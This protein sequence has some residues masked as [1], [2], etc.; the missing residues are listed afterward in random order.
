MASG[1]NNTTRYTAALAIVAVASVPTMARAQQCEDLV[2]GAALSA[3]G[4]YA[5]NGT[6]T[7]N[8]Y[9]FAVKKV[10][11][12]G[13]IKIGG[14]CYH[15]SI[16]Y[17][18]DESTPARAAQLVERLINQDDIKFVLGP[19]SSPMTKAVLPVTEKYKISVVQAEAASRSLLTQGYAYHFGIIATSGKSLTPVIQKTTA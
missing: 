17:Y 8:G 12:A 18:D 19:Y 1:P 16:K 10:N 11:E 4:I 14:K 15:L 13:G 2:L 7:K 5:S 3:T 9:D 6:N